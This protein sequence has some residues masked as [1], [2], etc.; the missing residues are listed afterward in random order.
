M[1][2]R[3]RSARWFEIL[4]SKNACSRTLG[5]LAGLG[6]V[7]VEVHPQRR[8]G[9]NPK[10]IANGLQ[11]YQRLADR[12]RPYW[13]G[14]L[15]HEPV[16]QPPEAVLQHAMTQ[17]ALW[18]EEADPLIGRIEALQAERVR[19][20]R[21]KR[22]LEELSDG[23]LDFA[24]FLD[25]GPLLVTV[26]AIL[27]SEAQ[28]Q[29]PDSALGLLVDGDRE[30][31]LLAVVADSDYEQLQR[32]IKALEGTVVERPPWLHG[33]VVQ[34][35][36]LVLGRLSV[37]NAELLTLQARLDDWFEHFD[38]PSALGETA[39]LQWFSEQ[40]GALPQA[41]DNFTWIT[42]WTS[43]GDD[44]RLLRAL[45]DGQVPALYHTPEP[46]PGV[47][48]PQLLH[49]PL[50]ARPFEFFA[51]AFGTPGCN[52]ADPSASL[53]VIVPLLFGYMFGDLGQGLLLA[54][55][56][57][58]LRPRWSGAGVLIAAGLSAAVFGL[59]FGS[60]FSREDWIPAL[61]FHPLQEPLLALL[62]PLGLG[63]AILLWG[64][65][66]NGAEAWWR[67][68][69]GQWLS[70]EAAL[71][72]MYLSAIGLLAHAGFRYPLIIGLFWFLL[73]RG[74]HGLFGA[75]AGLIEDGLRLLIN[76]VSFA[77]VGAFALAHAGLSSAL[78]TMAD[79]SGSLVWAGLIMLLGNALVI[80]LEG[81]VVSVQTTRLVLFEFFMR[82]LKGEGRP[83]RPI[84]PPPDLLRGRLS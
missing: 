14:R 72:L 11:A 40:V 78:M 84:A 21:C 75:L 35:R 33:D 67:G 44:R 82:F 74:L 3:P 68:E 56:G 54:A 49:N 37:I 9:I 70:H 2:L 63:V 27:P 13:R 47:A 69:I 48:P 73:G 77:R 7:E 43:E 45:T 6:A 81:L 38:L 26:T 15:R 34:A 76:T 52:E 80:L 65:M 25:A 58:W 30:T 46:P 42:G 60:L 8:L 83:F 55:L 18:R 66:L 32:H 59:L 62:L 41:G 64:Q 57:W 19:L 20:H 12:Y 22:I 51:R 31:Y 28:W 23:A 61:L 1:S 5:T 50:W 24:A 16:T 10:A 29:W 17:I 79:G 39:C 4:A 36:A 53:G 71:M